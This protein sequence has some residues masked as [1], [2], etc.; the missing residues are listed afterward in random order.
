MDCN[1]ARHLLQATA[2]G[3]VGA[4]DSVRLERHLEDCDGCVEALGNLQGLRRATRQGATYHRAPAELR[5]RILDALPDPAEDTLADPSSATTDGWRRWFAWS[6]PVNAALAAV[7]VAAVGLG[8]FQYNTQPSRDDLLAGGIVASHV[9]GLIS[10]RASDVISTDQHTVKPW[11]NG[12]IDYA[13]EVRDLASA[14]FPLVGGRV[15]FVDG[16]RVAV[17]VYRRNQHPVDVFVMPGAGAGVGERV[18]QG[19]Q[20]E[21]WTAGGMRY[22]AITDASA[23]DLR[24]FVQAW[25]NAEDGDRA[26][27]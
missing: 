26:M 20:L 17:L 14:G 21:G 22:V 24:K 2:D 16:Q 23:G 18:R 15:D 12:R 6:P 27:K 10:N 7:T 13:P 1:E 5:A 3:E 11:F 25:R 8:L 9:R 4:A 19:Y